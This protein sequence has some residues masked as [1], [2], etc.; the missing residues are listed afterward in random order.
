[1]R[2]LVRLTYVATAL[3]FTTEVAVLATTTACQVPN[4]STVFCTGN[5]ENMKTEC[6]GD[7]AHCDGRILDREKMSL[8]PVAATA[9]AT[10][11]ESVN[12]SRECTCEWDP[13]GEGTCK[14]VNC[15]EYSPADKT[16]ADPTVTCPTEE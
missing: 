13:T 9:G 5:D 12:C 10:T 11:Q 7:E 16:V 15:T 4:P 1:M 14:S 3:F 2:N 8:T 6:T